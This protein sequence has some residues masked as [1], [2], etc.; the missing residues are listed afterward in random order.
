MPTA[1]VVAEAV[2]KA[3][4]S[5]VPDKTIAEGWGSGAIALGGLGREPGIA[6]KDGS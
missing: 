2:L 6:Q 5:L 3:I 1:L 4:G